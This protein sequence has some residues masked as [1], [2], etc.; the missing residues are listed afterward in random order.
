MEVVMKSRSRKMVILVF[1]ALLFTGCHK[2]QATTKIEP[3][4]SG[5]LQIG[6]GFSTEEWANME[7]QNNNAQDFCNTSH[8]PPN[9]IVIEEQRGEETWCITTTRFKNLEELRSLYEQRKG[10]KI[11]HLEISDGAFSYDID[12]DTLSDDSNFSVMTEITWS[13]V[14]PGTVIDHNADLVDANTLTW[15]PTPQ[16]GIINLRAVS[17]VPQTG[18]DFPSCGAALIGFSLVIIHFR[19]R[20]R[21]LPLP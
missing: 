11:N 20:G 16:S 14:L 21:N 9:V 4:G 15:N 17:E 1:G 10:I 3:N 7:K 13:V 12:L 2:L 5:E 8:M 19:R 18:F 6:A